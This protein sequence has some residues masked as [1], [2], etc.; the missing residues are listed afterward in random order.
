MLKAYDVF[1]KCHT[2]CQTAVHASSLL[3][4]IENTSTWTLSNSVDSFL[5]R[6]VHM[7]EDTN[8]SSVFEHIRHVYEQETWSEGRS[9]IIT[10]WGSRSSTVDASEGFVRERW[11]CRGWCSPTHSRLLWGQHR[12]GERA[13]S[14]VLLHS[15]FVC[16]SLPRQTL[17][18]CQQLSKKEQKNSNK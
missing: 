2:S 3:L 1:G 18:S 17:H 12:G 10:A 4:C 14:F 5:L 13:Y 9:L 7:Y 6:A 15:F 11:E 16:F 8:N